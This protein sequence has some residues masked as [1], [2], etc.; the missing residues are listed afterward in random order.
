MCAMHSRRPSEDTYPDTC[1]FNVPG[2][3]KHE[4]KRVYFIWLL[5]KPL[6]IR[7]LP[8]AIAHGAEVSA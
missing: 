5:L 6:L 8:H 3:L 4:Y 7:V 2:P 1:L